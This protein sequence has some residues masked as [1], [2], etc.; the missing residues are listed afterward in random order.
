M[1]AENGEPLAVLQPH[2]AEIKAAPFSPNGQRIVTASDD[3]VTRLWQV[4]SLD[5]STELL[6]QTKRLEAEAAAAPWATR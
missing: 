5:S 3:A 6:A 1:D 2:F 4:R